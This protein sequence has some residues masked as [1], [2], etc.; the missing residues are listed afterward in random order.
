MYKAMK[1]SIFESAWIGKTFDDFLFRPQKGI[2]SSRSDISLAAS[3][4]SR[5][6]LE[7]PIISSNMDSVTGRRMAETMA[8]EGGLGVI[9]R[10]QSIEKQAALVSR[11]KRSHSAVIENPL[12][13]PITATVG[14]AKLF[15]RRHNINGL[16]IETTEG[17]GVLAGVLTRRDIPWQRDFDNRPVAEFMT[18]F[19][20]LTTAPADVSTEVAEQIMF[21]GRFERLPLING[22]SEERRVGQECRSR[23]S[24]YP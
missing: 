19:D 18:T 13:L 1:E 11:V 16:L 4:T 3:L 24:P 21:K 6:S 7:L 9:H 22:R 2:T 20:H 17:S 15:A 14:E 5:I 10:G 23:W 8:L 12:C